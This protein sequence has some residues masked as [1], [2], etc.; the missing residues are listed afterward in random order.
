MELLSENLASKMEEKRNEQKRARTVRS[1]YETDIKDIQNWISDV[2][3]KIDDTSV[4]PLKLDEYIKV[5]NN[6]ICF[7]YFIS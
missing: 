7:L 5:C 4:E 1:D 2:E 3:L 6:S